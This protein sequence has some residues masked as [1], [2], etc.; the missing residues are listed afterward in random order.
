MN[1]RNIKKRKFFLKGLWCI[2]HERRETFIDRLKKVLL[3]YTFVFSLVEE[4]VQAEARR[5]GF[6]KEE[7][8]KGV[9]YHFKPRRPLPLGGG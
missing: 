1:D 2:S 3:S 5:Q 6:S 8:A 7:V 9:V 4:I